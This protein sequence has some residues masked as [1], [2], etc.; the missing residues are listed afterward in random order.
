MDGRLIFVAST[1]PF[2]PV[3]GVNTVDRGFTTGI[4]D[5]VLH[6][7]STIVA[8]IFLAGLA[9][10]PVTGTTCATA[11]NLFDCFAGLRAE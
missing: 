8:G 4:A 10:A 5:L 11:L 9:V 1:I 3:G 6:R 2:N 7:R